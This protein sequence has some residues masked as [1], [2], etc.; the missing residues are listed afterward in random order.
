MKIQVGKTYKTGLGESVKIVQRDESDD[1]YRGSD[2]CWYDNS[3]RLLGFSDECRWSF[4]EEVLDAPPLRPDIGKTYRTNAGEV[5]AM[6]SPTS[7]GK[8]CASNGYYYEIDGRWCGQDSDY[9]NSIASEVAE[10]TD[11]PED[12]E[13]AV[14]D[15]WVTRGGI[16]VKIIAT[17]IPGDE[18]VAGYPL[19]YDY[20]S[21][22][23]ASRVWSFSASGR[24]RFDEE[25]DDDLV[26]KEER[27]VAWLVRCADGSTYGPTREESSADAWVAMLEGA[28]KHP[29][30]ERP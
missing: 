6:V 22:P 3:G 15:V 19:E 14:G 5:V 16:R 24:M 13:I 4:I 21:D 1:T 12:L 28:T 30:F 9:W 27:P 18:P 23:N 11:A 25:G 2:T 10:D 7:S 17:D 26:S 29:L 8:V 20:E